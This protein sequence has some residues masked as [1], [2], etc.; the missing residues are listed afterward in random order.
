MRYFFLYILVSICSVA[1][2]STFWQRS[3]VNYSRRTYMAANQNWMVKQ[4]QN[5]WMYFANNQGL[6]EYDGVYWH[7]YEITNRAKLRSILVSQKRIYAGGLGQF[8]FFMPDEKGLLKYTSLA[9]QLK[10][11]EKVNIWNIHEL[12]NR[13]YF[14]A[15]NA[16]Y[17][18]ENGKLGKIACKTGINYSAVIYN[19]LYVAM[20]D[21]VYV[22]YGNVFKKDNNVSLPDNANVVSML[23]YDHQIMFVT[24]DHGVYLY[25]F[26]HCSEWESPANAIIRQNKLTCASLSKSRI[27]L[28]TTQNGVILVNTTNQHV[29]NISM[30]NGLQNQTVLSAG[31]DK[32]DNLWVGLDNGIDYVAL[33]SPLFF[34]NGKSEAIGAGYCSVMYQNSLYLGTNQGVYQTHGVYDAPIQIETRFVEGTGGQVHCIVPFDNKLF[35]GGRNFFIMI[36]GNHVVKYPIRG[37]WHVCQVGNRDDVL[38]L[39]DYWG[40]KTLR[41]TAN[42]WVVSDEIEGVQLSAKNMMVE[43]GTN[44]VWVANKAMG[45]FRLTLDAQ[46]EHVVR[47]KNFNSEQLPVGDNIYV[48]TI[49]HEVVIASRQGL[50]RYDVAQ[51]DIVPFDRLEKQLNGKAA[52]TYISQDQQH[53]IWYVCDG[54][55]NLLRYDP[56]KKTYFKHLGESYLNDELIEDFESVMA[57]DQQ[58]AVIGTQEG[59]ALLRYAPA[60][61]S[62]QPVTLQIR[63]VIGTNG[64]DT[65]LY[66]CNFYRVQKPLRFKYKDNS[67]RIE[68]SANNY[69]KSQTVLYSYRLKGSPDDSWSNYSPQHIKE[70]TNLHEGSY[71]FEVR[72]VTDTN[73]E[74]SVTSLS[75]RILPPWYRSWWMYLVYFALLAAVVY[76]IIY[77]ILKG[78]KKL[79]QKIETLEDEKI[80]IELRSKENELMLSR[81]NVV[82]KNEMLM[83]IKKTA[84]SLNNSLKEENLPTI[85]RKVVRLIG[86]I[87]TNIEHDE[88]LEAFKNEYD[89]IHHNFLMTLGERFP[90]LTH[91]DKMLCVYLKMNMISKE[92]APLLNISVRGVEI[93]RYR[94]RKKLGLGEKE[95]LSDF[96]RNLDNR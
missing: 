94:L 59:F 88:D 10:M 60:A 48:A 56:I 72:I 82:R 28:G 24:S 17:Y 69:D 3:V 61:S 6:L 93:S 50:F 85:K 73:L 26:D 23:P 45:L 68:Y 66:G 9:D 12:G 79:D 80:Q 53:N 63:R 30:E 37:V 83:E 29:E 58:Q 95:S 11:G 38:L 55:L 2:S 49:D 22:L 76:A 44:A 40:L 75:F 39:G 51:D 46:L 70:Y 43:E 67:I 62:R 41:K 33:N 77:R 92:I 20:S 81:M 4:A 52:Y 86:Q 14:Q 21:G 25:D 54:L 13:V 96:L 84:V 1:N 19:K 5:G 57:L 27:A 7:H 32:T 15:D 91:K 78:K 74:P 31:F 35:C 65:L 90:Q 47:T 8:G 16:V 64:A 36:D 71:T 89:A 42:S 87:D 34:L 18:L